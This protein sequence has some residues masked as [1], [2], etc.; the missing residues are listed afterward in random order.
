[1]PPLLVVAVTNFYRANEC[2]S[3]RKSRSGSREQMRREGRCFKC[4]H[5]GHLQRECKRRRRSRSRSDSRR[6]R[7]RSS[8][9]ESDRSRKRHRKDKKKSSRKHKRRGRS[10]SSRSSRSSRSSKSRGRD[11][12]RKRSQSPLSKKSVSR[13]ASKGKPALENSEITK[14]GSAVPTNGA[15]EAAAT[16]NSA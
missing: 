14:E 5:R 9:S 8:S 1:M 11:R 12:D 3:R 2:R 7:S 10:S 13:S 15:A 4:G 16:T 6:R